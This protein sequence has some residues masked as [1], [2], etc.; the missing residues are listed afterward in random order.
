MHQ[1]PQ[2]QQPQNLP[3]PYGQHPGQP[4]YP[5][6]TGQVQPWQQPWPVPY[7]QQVAPKNVLGAVAISFFVPGTGLL[8]AGQKKW[9]TI[10]LIAWLVSIPLVLATIGILTGGI[11]WIAGMIAAGMA[12]S[13]WNREHGIIS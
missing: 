3:Q 12:A 6:Q 7:P 1:H 11:C 13:R 4:P 8:Y 5:P 2:G 10:I 9:G